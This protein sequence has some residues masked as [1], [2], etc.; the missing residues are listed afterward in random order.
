VDIKKLIWP[1]RI[2]IHKVRPGEIA[3]KRGLLIATS[4]AGKLAELGALLTN[5]PFA[6]FSLADYPQIQIVAE[7]GLTFIEN[8]SI[9]ASGYARQTGLLTLADDSGLEV[10]GLHGAPGVLSARY[11]NESA[12]Y[13]DRIQALLTELSGSRGADRVARFVCAVAISGVDGSVLHVS[14]GTC[15]GQLA[16]SPRGSGGFG[17][18]PIFVPDGY[19]LTFAELSAR[20][21]NQISH[22]A[23]A[24][25]EAWEFLHCLTGASSAG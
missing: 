22:R 11:L 10:E 17:Y 18:D 2:V 5:L 14:V 25:R 16:K 20:T 3:L 4:N 19:H 15:K 13:A 8:A 9:K 21:K 12:S 23:R 1:S 24:L 6:L 7:T